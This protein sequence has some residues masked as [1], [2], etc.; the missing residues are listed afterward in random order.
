[1]RRTRLLSVC[2]IVVSVGFLTLLGGCDSGP[3]PEAV[4]QTR[5]NLK[6]IGLALHNYRDIAKAL[7]AAYSVDASGKPCLGWRVHLLYSL[8]EE[9]LLSQFRLNEPWDSPHN[10]ALV[11]RMPDV[12]RS[13][14]SAA[15]PG[16]TVYLGNAA[17]GGV[18]VP[19]RNAEQLKKLAGTKYEESG[20]KVYSYLTQG[21]RLRDVRDGIANTIAVVEVNDSLAVP[22][23][24]PDD[25]VPA[26]DDPTK[27]LRPIRENYLVLLCD[28]AAM[29][30]SNK[31]TKETIRGL[32]TISGGEL[33]D[34]V[35]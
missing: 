17:D 12:Y 18:F 32:M 25:F 15:G 33:I 11:D 24:K 30:V 6:Q 23:T 8:G 13:P 29:I 5:D 26:A 22:W 10:L 7:P 1:M 19:P 31:N 16:K 3:T 14:L 21:T 27:G 28:G 20:K 35:Q 4:N 9:E 2:A 34:L